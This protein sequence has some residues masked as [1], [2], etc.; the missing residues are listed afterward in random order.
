MEQQTTLSQAVTA[1][2]TSNDASKEPVGELIGVLSSLPKEPVANLRK[3]PPVPSKEPVAELINISPLRSIWLDYWL[4]QH[5]IPQIVARKYCYEVHYKT[6]DKQY[7]AIGFPNQA[8]G[9]H[10]RNRYHTMSIGKTGPTHLAH[11][12]HQLAVF[13]DFVDLL[14]LV[15]LLGMT[16]PQLP[17][18]LLL[19]RAD[20]VG[21]LRQ[22]EVIYSKVYL[23]LGTDH[24]SNRLAEDM[25]RHSPPCFDQRR[26]FA[27]YKSLN[28]WACHFGKRRPTPF[29]G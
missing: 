8:G 25:L 18:L 14:T 5:R 15:S 4:W 20:G 3:D 9:W 7:A 16:N 17:D 11:G 23:F 28:D 6:G 29:P 12:A 24:K 13:S 2:E 27:G 1:G 22:I 21:P 10:L 26:L 19:D